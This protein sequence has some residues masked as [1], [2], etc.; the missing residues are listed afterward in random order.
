MKKIATAL[1]LMLAAGLQAQSPSG[2][3]S[4]VLAW[5]ANPPEDKVD[6]YRVE[7]LEE[8]TTGWPPIIEAGNVTEF[9]VT[10][11]KA[12]T[13]Y[14]FRVLAHAGELESA[15]SSP[16]SA[17]P[18]PPF[19]ADGSCS[20]VPGSAPEVSIIVQSYDLQAKRSDPKGLLVRFDA[21][22]SEPI[23]RLDLDLENDGEP[24]VPVTFPAGVGFDGRYVRAL[25]F[26]PTIN[27]TWPLLVVATDAVG[28]KASARCTP[29]VTVGF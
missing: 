4:V 13:P 14:R 11:L 1:I 17:T 7:V 6:G 23:V 12:N 15:F 2:S 27:G 25:A 3:A 21:G 29:G 24:A 16:V 26:K 9:K 28:R 5:D 8:G 20:T 10:G 18:L 22:S 19:G